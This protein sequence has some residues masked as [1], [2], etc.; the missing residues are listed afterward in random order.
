[1]GLK[2]MSAVSK[3]AQATPVLGKVAKTV[4]GVGD[5]RKKIADV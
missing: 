3:V 2:P 5:T 1:M 4:P